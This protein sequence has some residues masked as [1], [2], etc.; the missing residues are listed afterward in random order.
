MISQVKLAELH[1]RA[2]VSRQKRQDEINAETKSDI[3]CGSS[4]KKPA[5]DA[6]R[7][8]AINHAGPLG[9]LDAVG[10]AEESW[11][12]L[13]ASAPRC[14]LPDPDCRT[15]TAFVRQMVPKTA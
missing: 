5:S 2:Y 10:Q 6:W 8:D 11:L 9:L 3:D 13:F 14:V 4:K 12:E 7:Q 1:V 15:D